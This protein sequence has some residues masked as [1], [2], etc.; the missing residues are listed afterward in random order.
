M[1]MTLVAA[2]MLCCAFGPMSETARAGYIVNIDAQVYGYRD[3]TDPAPVPGQLIDPFSL[4][5][6]GVLNQLT[7]GAGDY[8]ITNAT[9]LPG[10]N[11]GFNAW[12]YNDGGNSWVW[13]FV[14]ADD[15]TDRVLFYGEA[16]VGGSQGAVASHSDVQNFS[17]TFSLAAPTTVNFM[18][19]DYFLTDNAGGVALNIEPAAVEAVPEPSSV[20]LLTVGAT[21]S[22]LGTR[23]RRRREDLS[24]A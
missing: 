3:P 16:G 22:V 12:R 10:A 19:R 6:G 17:A 15:A 7:L 13:I 24:V 21:L 23:L 2:G 5:P 20:I 9:G 18:I 1:K 14:L 4:A 11:P 8:T